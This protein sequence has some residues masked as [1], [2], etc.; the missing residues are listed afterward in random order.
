MRMG[1]ILTGG[2]ARGDVELAQRAEEAGFDSVFSI[3]FLNNSN[4]AI[5]Q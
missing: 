4:A 1:L 5:C 3:A 2:S